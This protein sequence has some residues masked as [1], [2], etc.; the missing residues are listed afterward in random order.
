LFSSHYLEKPFTQPTPVNAGGP[1]YAADRNAIALYEFPGHNVL[2]HFIT[3]MPVRVS[4]TRGLGAYA[5]VF[6]IESF[7][8]ELALAAN[9]DPLAYRLRFLKDQRA[10]DTLQK[11]ADAFGWNTWKK[12]ANRGKGIG[13]A[14]YKNIAGYCAVAME[15]EVNPKNGRIRVLRAVASAEVGRIVNPDGVSNQIEG[16]LIQSL[17][18]TLKEEVKFDD[19]Q[20]LSTDWSSY[21]ILTFSEIPPV[22]VVLIDRPDMPFLGIG[23]ASQGPTC[24]ALAN[25]VFDATGARLRRLP[26]TPERVKAALTAKT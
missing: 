23:E 2:T 1:N 16:G 12:T 13:F 17:S 19:T 22:E 7:M 4:S 9:V 18:W 21:P 11:A 15:V 5:N 26:F 3:E 14:R 24:A 6:A 8:D 10:R 20:I 25:A